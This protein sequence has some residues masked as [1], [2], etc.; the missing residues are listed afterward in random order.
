V[1]KIVKGAFKIVKKIAKG[2]GKIF[3]K[4]VTSK[5]FKVVLAAVAIY[6]GGVAL[7]A[8]GGTATATGTAAG[9]G[10]TTGGVAATGTSTGI[11]AATTP[12][13]VTSAMPALAPQIAT[14]AGIGSTAAAATTQAAAA[15]GFFTKALTFMK[16]NPQL[17]SMAFQGL[18]SAF[19]PDEMDIIDAQGEQQRLQL[20]EQERLRKERF[21]SLSGI[22]DIKL[23]LAPGESILKTMSG[24]PWHDRLK[25]TSTGG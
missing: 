14:T 8:W 15:G 11:A 20:Q 1:S 4:V 10:A 24:T 3:K 6:S 16:T 19:A 5:I 23:D 2:V 13:V 25:R 7:G 17:T 12:T 22:K 21:A 9:V 18:S